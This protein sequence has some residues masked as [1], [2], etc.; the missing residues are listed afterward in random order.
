MF[1]FSFR[2]IFCHLYTSILVVQMH[3]L[4]GKAYLLIIFA[5]LEHEPQLEKPYDTSGWGPR[6]FGVLP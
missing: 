5:E 3:F 4:F 2:H 1:F 6:N